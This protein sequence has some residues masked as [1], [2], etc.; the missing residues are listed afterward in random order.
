MKNVALSVVVFMLSAALFS[1]T[2]SRMMQSSALED[3]SLSL[4]DYEYV[5]IY[6]SETASFIELE[7]ETLFETLGLDVVGEKRASGLIGQGHNVLAA[8]YNDFVLRNG[9]G[10]PIGYELSVLL[11]DLATDRT[12]LT[13]SAESSSSRQAAWKAVQS[14]LEEAFVN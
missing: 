2:S 3:G 11:Q 6:D 7:L 4:S 12:L 13:A 8:R 9:Y 10:N 5:T 14:E 1:C